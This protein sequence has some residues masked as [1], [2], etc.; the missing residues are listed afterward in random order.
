MESTFQIL[1]NLPDVRVL[2]VSKTEDGAWIIRLES[3]L[4]RATCRRCGREIREFH[5]LGQPLRVRHLPI[6]EQPVFLEIRPKRFRCQECDAHPSSTQRCMWYEERS[7]NTKAYE[8]MALR[9]LINS[10]VSD[11]ARKLQ[12]GEE[13]IEGI[14]DR[15]IAT[16]VNWAEYETLPLIGI[17]EIALKKGH[18]NFVAIITTPLE[19]GGVGILG[20][21]KDR[22]KETVKSFL[23][24]IPERLKRTIERVC[25]DMHEGYVRAVEEEVPW[26]KVVADRFHVAKAYGACVDE[27]RKKELGTLKKQMSKA[28]YEPLKGAM[29][30]LR[31]DP[32]ELEVEERDLLAR[33]F[34]QAPVLEKVYDLKQKLTQ[35]FELPLSKHGAQCALQAWSKEVQATGVTYFDSFLTTL[36][37]WMDEITNYFLERETSGFV[38]G[39]NN[40]IKVLKRRCYGIFNVGRIFQRLYLDVE[41]YRLFGLA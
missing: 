15:Y 16:K 3:T 23:S 24:G 22:K 34:E 30:P 35:I 11:A 12:V 10:T 41:G 40:K 13:T 18:R 7:P 26:A 4:T 37:G 21:L 33:V 20:V 6:F 39:F 19:G 2:E 36:D 17:D 25:T 29:W 9:V 5:S 28:E 14:L 31:K 32:Q 27:A 1:L 38:E 8:Q